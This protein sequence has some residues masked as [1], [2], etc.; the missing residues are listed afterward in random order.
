MTES[1]ELKDDI[2][3][4]IEAL[5]RSRRPA[6]SDLEF[7]SQERWSQFF[8]FAN[9]SEAEAFLDEF[10]STDSAN[11]KIDSLAYG[12]SLM[13]LTKYRN[14]HL[15]NLADWQKMSS[16]A[17]IDRLVKE[18]RFTRLEKY[19]SDIAVDGYKKAG[20]NL[21]KP[22][23]GLKFQYVNIGFF[24][25]LEL[26]V[27][28]LILNACERGF[29]VLVISSMALIYS[30][31]MTTMLVDANGGSHRFVLIG[32]SLTRIRRLL[33]DH[34]LDGSRIDEDLDEVEGVMHRDRVVYRILYA[35]YF[36]IDLIAAIE[37]LRTVF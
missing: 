18:E 3:E 13:A 27:G 12:V 15:S 5:K 28:L 1:D 17:D 6:R 9:V 32:T 20:A 26:V 4:A 24:S 8:P 14:T 36:M 34:L 10:Y 23:R 22:D 35:K 37:I 33:H 21:Q 11:K 19:L 7:L 30:R 31:I 29:Q 25:L 2:A 16:Q